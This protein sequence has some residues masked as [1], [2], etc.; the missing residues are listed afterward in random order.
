MLPILHQSSQ[1]ANIKR[2]KEESLK[3]GQKYT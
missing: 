3:E 1:A 2:N